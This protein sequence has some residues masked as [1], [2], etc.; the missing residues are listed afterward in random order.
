MQHNMKNPITKLFI[1]SIVIGSIVSITAC[2]KKTSTPTATCSTTISYANDIVPMMTQ[3]CTSCHNSS[4]A[5][6]GYN[7]TTHANV[8]NN[9]SIVL[10]SMRHQ[11]GA[12]PMPQGSSQL[13]ST[14]IDK[15]DC[16]IQ[17]GKPN[18]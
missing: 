1:A 10:N 15:F 17:Q 11:N 12:T 5:S 9:A 18:N 3:N 8:S 7:L 4:N 6:G 13:P 14:T 16:W 2:K